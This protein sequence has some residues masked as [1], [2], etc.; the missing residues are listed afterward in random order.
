[1]IFDNADGTDGGDSRNCSVMIYNDDTQ[2]GNCFLLC[3]IWVGITARQGTARHGTARHS[4]A[5]QRPQARL[6]A[7]LLRYLL[8]APVHA[9]LVSGEG[10]VATHADLRVCQDD[11]FDHWR[12]VCLVR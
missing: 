11:P 12:D 3:Y 4:N 8:G 2:T 5:R 10:A 1:M 9:R 6:W 7:Y